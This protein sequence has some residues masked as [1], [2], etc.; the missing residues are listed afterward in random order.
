VGYALIRTALVLAPILLLQ[1]S[2]ALAQDKPDARDAAVVQDC[3]KA[4]TGAH[5]N[6][7]HCIGIISEVCSKDEP[8]MAPSEV[9]AC[10]AREQVVWDDI[11]NQSYRRLREALD[12]KQQSKLRE[13]QRA[14]I[15]SRDK[16]CAFIYDYFQG[17]MA[18]PM[19][20][21]CMSRATGMQALFLLGFANDVAERK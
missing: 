7:E 8:S 15:A 13:M 17:S 6:W 10:Y 21:A 1:A 11:L 4:K 19:M 9:I 2:P 20:A 12:D 3:I 18:N 5:W 14:W 16:N